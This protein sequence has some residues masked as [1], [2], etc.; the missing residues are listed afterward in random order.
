M[1]KKVTMQH[2]AD[3]LGISK[4][5]VS[6]ALS[7]KQGVSE[8]S[9]KRVI[10]AA[11]ELGYFINKGTAVGNP[12]NEI[13]ASQTKKQTVAVLMPNIRFQ[14]K[15]SMFWGKILEGITNSLDNHNIGHVIISETS[16]E[17]FKYFMNPNGLLGI[18]GVGMVNT[19]LMLE[20]HQV[21]IPMVWIDHEDPLVQTDTVFANNFASTYRLTKNL[22]G[23][24]HQRIEFLGNIKYSKSFYDRWLGFRSAI[25]ESNIFYHPQEHVEYLSEYV[26]GDPLAPNLTEL[27]KNVDILQIPTAFVCANDHIALEVVK[28][29]KRH[30]VDVPGDVSVTGF[31][32]N[33]NAK[34]ITTVNVDKR[35][36]GKRA[37]ELLLW[38]QKNREDP[39]Q[40]LLVSG[41]IIM[42]ESSSN[43]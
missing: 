36:L 2:I 24:G 39:I 31:D 6:K 8:E 40:R 18:I 12:S 43:P 32:N 42:R 25:E 5:V 33:E 1:G 37:T 17:N 35:L 28:T 13:S 9:R 23:L 22:L 30:D 3:R 41:N 15:E 10:K 38:R 21:G 4:F 26:E 14:T 16:I 27:F 19:A 7:G 11:T 29:L 20:I 34:N